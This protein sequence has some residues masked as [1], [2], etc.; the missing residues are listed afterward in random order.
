[1]GKLIEEMTRAGVLLA[2]CGLEPTPTRV[3]YSKGKIEI[4]DGPFTEA[5][6][7]IDRS[8]IQRGSD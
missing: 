2:T 6:E 7:A 3:K 4:L 1:M 5:K 8:Q